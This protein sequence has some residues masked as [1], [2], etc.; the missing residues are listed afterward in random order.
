[1][2]CSLAK[3]VHLCLSLMSLCHINGVKNAIYV[4]TMLKEGRLE[5]CFIHCNR[6]Y[7]IFV[8]KVPQSSPVPVRLREADEEELDLKQSTFI[9]ISNAT[10][11][12]SSFGR[13]QH[14][15]SSLN[16]IRTVVLM[17]SW[18]RTEIPSFNRIITVIIIMMNDNFL[19]INEDNLSK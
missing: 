15:W 2:D 7:P 10:R 14:T 19:P 6:F 9:L 8:H 16:S 18:G 5:T 3:D 13:Q 12:S 1:M 11:E 17:K 4:I